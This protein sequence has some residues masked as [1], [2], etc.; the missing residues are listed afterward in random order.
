MGGVAGQEQAPRRQLT[1]HAGQ[2]PAKALGVTDQH[3]QLQL[4][5]E[6][7][8]DKVIT[9]IKVENF[10][11]ETK[12]PKGCEEFKDVAFLG[13]MT[14]NTLIEAERQGTEYALYVNRRMNQTIIMPEVNA[15]TL[16]QLMVPVGNDDRLRR[17]AAEYRRFQPAGRGNQQARD[18][19]DSGQYRRKV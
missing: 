16:G 1:A 14:H 18:V 9:F 11:A 8:F 10:R 2:T 6:G 3:S 5:N 4:Y 19:C 17:R 15:Y 12:I 7:P 13:G